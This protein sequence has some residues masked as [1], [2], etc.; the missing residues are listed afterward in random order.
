[1]PRLDTC[2][3]AFTAPA[4][5]EWFAEASPNDATTTASAGHALATPSLVARSTEN[6]VPRARG[7]CEAIVE[8]CGTTASSWLP[9][10]LCRP[11]EIGSSAAATR[12]SSTSR[13]ASVPGTCCARAT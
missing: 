12:P 9:N 11:P 8:V 1:M 4:A 13:T 2:T 5:V 10:T 6:A 3:A 7:R